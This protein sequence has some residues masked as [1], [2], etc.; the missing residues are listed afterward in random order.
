MGER[1]EG[2]TI[3]VQAAQGLG[4]LAS[5]RESRTKKQ[6]TKLAATT[7]PSPSTPAAPK[8][9]TTTNMHQSTEKDP[10][11]GLLST[12]LDMMADIMNQNNQILEE[13]KRVAEENQQLRSQLGELTDQIGG[14]KTKIE[15]IQAQMTANHSSIGL[16][17]VTYANVL[18]SANSTRSTIPSSGAWPTNSG[19][20]NPGSSASAI[21]KIDVPFC[22]IDFSR[23][24]EVDKHKVTPSAIRKLVNSGETG[25]R[26]RSCAV[27]M[28]PRGDPRLRVTCAT[29]EE[30]EEVKKILD[31]ESI[32]GLRVLK[33]QIYPV[34]V[35]AVKRSS[36]LDEEG[37]LRPG[38]VREMEEENEVSIAK[39]SWLSKKDVPKEYGSMVVYTTKSSEAVRLLEGLYFHVQGLAGY[40]KTYVAREGPPQCYNCQQ[41]GHKAYECKAPKVC[42]RCAGPGHHHSECAL[43]PKCTLCRGPHE[44]FSKKCRKLYPTPHA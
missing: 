8:K 35:D 6:T 25:G 33:D 10:N 14:L 32:R 40:T 11:E 13:N 26:K 19:S 5:Q 43:E 17:P 28:V 30:K 16:S 15:D 23:V 3:T 12:M 18:K 22:T 7:Q 29:E 31:R 37:N 1:M 21:P 41:L 39:V 38:V 42:G 2:E 44:A 9:R 27:T 20:I 36:V 24:D 4:S 34:K